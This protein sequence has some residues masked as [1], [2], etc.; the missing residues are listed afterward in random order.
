[1]KRQRLITE[2]VFEGPI[3]G[4][5][6]Q[7]LSSKDSVEETICAAGWD[8][9]W[10][11]GG[12]MVSHNE[13]EEGFA[14]N[15]FFI[16]DLNF[17]GVI[18]SNSDMASE[19]VSILTYVLIDQG[20]QVPRPE[21]FLGVEKD[22]NWKPESE[23]SADHSDGETMRPEEEVRQELCP[24]SKS[25]SALHATFCKHCGIPEPRVPKD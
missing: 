24:E 19:V 20:M 11:C 7:D 1:M 21:S 5:I 23:T 8:I 25:W 6:L 14:C 9:R 2:G 15:Y 17:E 4:R 16:P 22:L 18:M 12:K 3:E 13:S 10:Y